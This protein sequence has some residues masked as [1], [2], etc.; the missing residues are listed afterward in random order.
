MYLS[1]ACV[2]KITNMTVSR[3]FC[4]NVRGNSHKFTL[5]SHCIP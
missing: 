5:Q 3:I 4:H 2:V 1:W